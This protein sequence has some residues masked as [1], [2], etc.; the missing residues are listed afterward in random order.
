MQLETTMRL[1]KK[2]IPPKTATTLPKQSNV[3][4]TTEN[5]EHGISSV[6]KWSS[7]Y[8][9]LWQLLKQLSTEL[10]QNTATYPQVHTCHN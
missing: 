2:R 1:K 6:G 7:Y 8:G 3:G 4:E 9:K 10:S 5:L